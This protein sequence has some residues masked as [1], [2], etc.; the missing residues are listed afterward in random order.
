MQTVLHFVSNNILYMTVLWLHPEDGGGHVPRNADI[1]PHQ[2][3]ED[4]DQYHGLHLKHSISN[5]SCHLADLLM[6]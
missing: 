3:T 1:P 5:V 2:N 4:Y 6:H